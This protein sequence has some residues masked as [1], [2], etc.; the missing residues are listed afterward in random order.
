M[1]I[2]CTIKR[3]GGTVVDLDDKTYH[4]EPQEDGRH[5]ADVE[6]EAHIER[7]LAVPESFRILRTKPSEAVNTI[8]APVEDVPPAVVIDA[9]LL[10]ST[11]HPASFEINGQAYQIADVVEHAFRDS[12]LTVEDWNGLDD[13][14]RA[15]K[16]DIVLDGIEAGDVEIEQPAV[17]DDRPALVA[18]YR[19]RFGKNP[20]RMTNENI[21]AALEKGE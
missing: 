21:K 1:K 16:I 8:I 19:E 17:E 2:E 11:S 4:F 20:G 18:A 3:E 5:V 7:F 10:G 9:E 12:G 15:T 13:E 6:I 14:T